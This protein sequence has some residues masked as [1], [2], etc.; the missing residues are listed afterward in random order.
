MTRVEQGL[1]AIDVAAALPP[2]KAAVESLQRAFGRSR[3]LLRSLAT[4][5]RLDPSRR[6]TGDLAGAIDWRRQ[7]REHE[8]REGDAVRRLLADLLDAVEAAAP[9]NLPAEA[10]R[11]TL[12]E[13]AL[14]VDP[15]S[16]VW[17]QMAQRLLDA[18]TAGEIDAIVADLTPLS[19]HGLSRPT[20]IQPADSAV[21]RAFKTEGRQ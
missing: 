6:L 7:E 14:A 13:S 9:G 21:V 8:P 15:A 2:A 1:T 12:A 16:A 11:R 20:G 10:R 17:Q 5:S 18:D 19:L 4:R 3:Y